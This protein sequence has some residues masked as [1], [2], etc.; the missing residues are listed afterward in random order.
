VSDDTADSAGADDE[1][2]VHGWLDKNFR[3]K[4]S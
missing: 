4:S 2:V 1:D 3:T